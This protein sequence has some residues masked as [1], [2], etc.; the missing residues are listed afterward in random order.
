MD[1]LDVFE[2]VLSQYADFSHPLNV[3][4]TLAYVS[5]IDDHAS[6]E[7]VDYCGRFVLVNEDSRE[8]V[9]EL[10]KK[11]SAQE[12]PTIWKYGHEK[13]SVAIE[14]PERQTVDDEHLQF[15]MRAI[16]PDHQD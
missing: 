15:F 6:K 12:G 11:M 7:L 9:G 10:D 16:Q 2:A 4:T 5:H 14:V 1:D 8:V 13:D 3:A